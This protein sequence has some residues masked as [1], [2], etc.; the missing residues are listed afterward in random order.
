[1][2]IDGVDLFECS[3]KC[4]FEIVHPAISFTELL[5]ERNPRHESGSFW[6]YAVKALSKPSVNI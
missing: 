2:R 5:P 1:M 6:I 4:G 3:A